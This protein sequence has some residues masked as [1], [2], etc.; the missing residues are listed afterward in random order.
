MSVKSI[1]IKDPN[2]I[3]SICDLIHDSWFEVSN[4]EFDSNTSVL[5]I[6]FER[7]LKDKSTVVEK[8]VCRKDRSTAGPVFSKYPSR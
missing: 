2:Q 1:S 8:M 4:I 7:E 6:Q 5:Y 3:P